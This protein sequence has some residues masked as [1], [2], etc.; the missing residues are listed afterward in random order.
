MKRSK[1]TGS[2]VAD[3]MKLSKKLWNK[4]RLRMETFEKMMEEQNQVCAI[5]KNPCKNNERLSV[6]HCHNTGAVRGLLCNNC[7]TGIGML[8]DDPDLVRRAFEYLNNA[9]DWREA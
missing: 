9:T 5:C 7:N 8:N 4:Y 6:D 1:S 3:Y 2:V